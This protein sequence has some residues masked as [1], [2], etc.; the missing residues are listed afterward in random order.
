MKKITF[1]V[2]MIVANLHSSLHAQCSGGTSGG[3]IYPTTVWKSVLTN[4]ISGGTHRTFPGV[5]GQTYYFSFC[6]ANGGNSTFDTQITIQN[7]N[8]GLMGIHN[9]DY[10]GFRSYL[11]FNCTATAN[12]RVYVTKFLCQV[13]ANIG[14]MVYRSTFNTPLPVELG[15]FEATVQG[16]NVKLDWIT[17]SEFN[18]DFFEVERKSNRESEFKTIATIKA[19]GNKLS[20]SSYVHIDT[21]PE[22]GINYYR[23]KQVDIN[24]NFD[25][26]KEISLDI[27][28]SNLPIALYYDGTFLQGAFISVSRLPLTLTIYDVTGRE[29]S[30]HKINVESGKNNFSIPMQLNNQGILVAKAICGNKEATIKFST[31]IHK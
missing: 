18:S 25:Y 21:Q 17:L 24:G 16:D 10:C 22:T 6:T 1:L 9:D 19:Q 31:V 5:A 2:A 29:I 4:P 7:N 12:Y 27:G 26:S 8:G 30:N 23:L 20:P 14:T 3:T 28:N 15:S 13:Q 11:V